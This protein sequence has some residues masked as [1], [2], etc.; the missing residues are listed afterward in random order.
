[1]GFLSET[2]SR[3]RRREVLPELDAVEREKDGEREKVSR[4]EADRLRRR[5]VREVLFRQERERPPVDGDVLSG[6]K[7]DE[8]EEQ[9][10]QEVH[11]WFILF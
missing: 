4:V 7:E 8:S 3:E 10:R 11:V 9:G 2:K 5:C 1:M 6:G